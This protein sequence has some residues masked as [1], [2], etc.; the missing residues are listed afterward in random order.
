MT[1]DEERVVEK[2]GYRIDVVPVAK[3]S[4]PMEQA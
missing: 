1:N 3:W 4:V 2:D